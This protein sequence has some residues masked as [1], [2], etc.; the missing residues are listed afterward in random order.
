MKFLT[1][2]KKESVICV[3]IMYEYVPLWVS[4]KIK[5]EMRAYVQLGFMT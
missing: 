3:T 5:L 4:L 2:S 1:A